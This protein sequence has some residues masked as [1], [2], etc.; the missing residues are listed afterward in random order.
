MSYTDSGFDKRVRNLLA[1]FQQVAPPPPP[2]PPAPPTGM[3]LWLKGSAIAVADGAPIDTWPDSSGNAL[4]ATAAGAQRPTFASASGI[5]GKPA[6]VFDDTQTQFF[7]LPTGFADFTAGLALYIVH[8]PIDTQALAKSLFSF[9]TNAVDSA[10]TFLIDTSNEGAGVAA[11]QPGFSFVASAGVQVYAPCVM[12]CR[13]PAGAAG[14]SV[15]GEVYLDHVLVASGAIQVPLNAARN[16][17]YV[18]QD[19]IAG[20]FRYAGEMADLLL[21]PVALT[22]AERAEV[23][24]Y[25]ADQ[26]GL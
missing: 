21:Y 4:D 10:Y 16:L 15:T 6:V 25:I 11:L 14:S 13:I 7:D 20:I 26:Y 2:P 23:D 22:P 12:E 17:N 24:A 5:N 19:A 8:S 18:G 1:A 9:S 3:L